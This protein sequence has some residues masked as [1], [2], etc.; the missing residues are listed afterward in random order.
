MVGPA[1]RLLS[2]GTF[3][4]TYDDEGSLI[5]KTEVA[6]GDVTQYAYDVSFRQ[7]CR[8][9]LPDDRGAEPGNA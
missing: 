5:T 6:S 2:D 1:N 7:A 8:D 4:Y 9:C 3:D